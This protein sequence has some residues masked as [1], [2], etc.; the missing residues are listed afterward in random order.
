M[1][2]LVS[3]ESLTAAPADLTD[4]LD[5][6]TFTGTTLSEAIAGGFVQVVDS[7]GNA[8]VNVDLDGIANGVSFTTIVTVSGVTASLIDDN[9]VVD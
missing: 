4:L 8:E 7:G 6:G 5:S 2:A 3:G 9:I 1:S